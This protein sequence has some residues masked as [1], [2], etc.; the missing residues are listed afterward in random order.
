MCGQDASFNITWHIRILV[1]LFT[2]WLLA[3]I[4]LDDVWMD[5]CDDGRYVLV[6]RSVVFNHLLRLV[7]M[8]FR[9][10]TL[11]GRLCYLWHITLSR[12]QQPEYSISKSCTVSILSGW[13]MLLS[14]LVRIIT[15]QQKYL[16]R[17]QLLLKDHV[18]IRAS[19]Y[20]LWMITS[21]LI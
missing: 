16:D 1:W 21:S 19:F 7:V 8:I 17:S 9:K 15:C 3:T 4:S 18:L 11:D 20:Y 6:N 14:T 13:Q 2:S 12:L 5:D 10:S